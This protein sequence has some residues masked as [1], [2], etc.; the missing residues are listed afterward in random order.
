ML[1]GLVVG[2]VGGG[3]CVVESVRE[4]NERV[5][6]RMGCCLSDMKRGRGKVSKIVGGMLVGGERR[7]DLCDGWRVDE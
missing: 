6:E 5:G 7:I 2:L 4:D 3:V 1:L